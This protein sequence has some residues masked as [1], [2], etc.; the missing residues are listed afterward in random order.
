[1]TERKR[2]AKHPM[3]PIVWDGNGVIRFQENPIVSFLLEWAS[4]RGMDLNAL[5][6]LGHEKHWTCD[7]WTQFAQLHGYSVGGWGSLGY[8]DD[9]AY[10][11]AQELT[12][13][14]KK[15]VPKDPGKAR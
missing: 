10:G 14:L 2:K 8:V 11:R 3:Q 9:E 7:D 15:R 5:E 1:M 4:A 13:E 6:V 12:E